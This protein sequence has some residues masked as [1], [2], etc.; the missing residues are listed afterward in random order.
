VPSPRR[1]GDEQVE[2]QIDHLVAFWVASLIG[3]T[4]GATALPASAF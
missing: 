4:L 3:G 2:L 1:D